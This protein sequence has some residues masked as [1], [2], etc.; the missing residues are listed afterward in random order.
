VGD[1]DLLGQRQNELNMKTTILEILFWVLSS[2]I[3]WADHDMSVRTRKVT[4][5]YPN[6]DPKEIIYCLDDKE[7]AKEA[8][9]KNHKAKISGSIPDGPVFE[10]DKNG[11]LRKRLDY[12]GNRRNGQMIWYYKNAI[13]QYEANYKDDKLDG[14]ERWYDKNGN[15]EKEINYKNGERK[16]ETVFKK[17][18]IEQKSLDALAP[19]QETKLDPDVMWAWQNDT[20]KGYF[21]VRPFPNEFSSKDKATIFLV[22]NDSFDYKDVEEIYINLSGKAWYGDTGD[23]GEWCFLVQG[24]MNKLPIFIEAVNGEYRLYIGFFKKEFRS[25]EEGGTNYTFYSLTKDI[26]IRQK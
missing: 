18:K 5:E 17:K 9:D 8:F 24:R 14:L 4:Q 2:G 15:I 20:T 10:Y 3:A 1:R 25:G 21:D 12:K 6:G 22:F 11:N 16:A 26:T 19:N 23:Y 7:V 13:V